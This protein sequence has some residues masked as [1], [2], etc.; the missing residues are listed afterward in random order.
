M[1]GRETNAARVVELKGALEGKLAGYE[2]ILSKHKYLAGDE[3]TL[4][5]LAHLPYGTLL[6]PQGIKFLE[7]EAKFPNVAR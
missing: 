5:D 7:D 1:F 2:K 4:A 6:A 3:V